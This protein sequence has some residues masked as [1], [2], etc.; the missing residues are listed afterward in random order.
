MATYTANAAQATVQPK[1][2]RVGL[3]AANAA[4]SFGVTPS[5]GDVFQMVK[6]PANATP[7][8]IQWQVTNGTPSWMMEVGDGISTARYKSCATV[9]TNSGWQIMYTNVLAPPA[10]YTY[11]AEDTIDVVYSTVTASNASP[12]GAIYLNAVFSM[13]P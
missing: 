10:P 2:L 6:V 7:V 13:N 3:I 11:S 1:G 9:S 12:G 5:T 8:F 4:F